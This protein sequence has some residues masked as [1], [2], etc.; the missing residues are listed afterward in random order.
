MD[1]SFDPDTGPDPITDELGPGDEVVPAWS[2]RL[3][4][5]DDSHVVTLRAPG[6]EHQN[7]MNEGIVQ[8][9]LAALLNLPDPMML[10]AQASAVST[11]INAA[12]RRALNTLTNELRKASRSPLLTPEARKEA[13]RKVL[14]RISLQQRKA[15]LMRAYLDA[16]KSP[17]QLKASRSGQRSKRSG[18][19]RS[20]VPK[21]RSKAGTKAQTRSKAGRKRK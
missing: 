16:F 17:S 7:L 1:A 10:L 19:A 21:E 3:V 15:L 14:R 13:V 12:S 20:K 8:E 18:R 6:L 4:S 2:A 5:L 11:P 9:E